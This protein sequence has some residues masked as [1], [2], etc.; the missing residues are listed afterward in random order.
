[1]SPSPKQPNESR[2][3]FEVRA[4]VLGVV[5]VVG[6]FVVITYVDQWRFP[7]Q[8]AGRA[9]DPSGLEALG[10]PRPALLPDQARAIEVAWD[11]QSGGA[12]LRFD[13]P[14]SLA[15]S[16]EGELDRGRHRCPELSQY[17]RVDTDFWCGERDDL[18]RRC[19]DGRCLYFDTAAHR[20]YLRVP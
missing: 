10:A 20:G 16:V 14:E 17:W 8:D 15:E 7:G 1:M 13:Y 4:L 12:M 9:E 3:S 5:F 6:L 2:V 18:R 19:D 11:T